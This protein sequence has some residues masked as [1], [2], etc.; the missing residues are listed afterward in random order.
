MR[1]ERHRDP[2]VT[3]HRVRQDPRPH[4]TEPTTREVTTSP[5]PCPAMVVQPPPHNS[6]P[7]GTIRV[8]RKRGRARPTTPQDD[9]PDPT[10]THAQKRRVEEQSEDRSPTPQFQVECRRRPTLPHPPR[11]STIGAGRLSFRVRKG[12]G[13]DPTAKTT[14]KTHETTHT[15]PPQWPVC[16][17][18][19]DTAQW[20]QHTLQ[21]TQ[22]STT[23]L[24]QRS[25]N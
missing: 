21:S 25:A 6:P 9:R 2:A 3:A 13:R 16:R 11:C 4:G 20:T 19:P 10:P 18:I 24:M 12:T 22:S 17:A 7:P 8:H 5:D 23:L 14:D 1:P 15:Q